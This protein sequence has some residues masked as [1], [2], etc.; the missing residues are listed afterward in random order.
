LSKIAILAFA[1]LTATGCNTETN[2]ELVRLR[3]DIEAL[4][5][6]QLAANRA[7]WEANQVQL[8]ANR[9]VWEANLQEA[10]ALSRAIGSQTKMSR[11]MELAL[12]GRQFSPPELIAMQ[13]GVQLHGRDAIPG[14]REDLRIRAIGHVASLK[15]LGA[16]IAG[17]AGLGKRCTAAL[18][19]LIPPE[20][21]KAGDAEHV[22]RV[23]WIA[24]E[25][26]NVLGG[27]L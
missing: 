11:I 12:S 7:V 6:V 20:E 24:E 23:E 1:I 15:R 18:D 16:A 10:S 4:S 5:Q 22:A 3:A 21:P 14:S 19:G 17:S 2:A 13:A 25:C 9:A 26:K 27:A 8:A